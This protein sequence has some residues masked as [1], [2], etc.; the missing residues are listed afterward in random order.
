MIN[1][2]VSVVV[3]RHLYIPFISSNRDTYFDNGIVPINC[4]NCRVKKR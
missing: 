3:L 2:K 1:I 4:R